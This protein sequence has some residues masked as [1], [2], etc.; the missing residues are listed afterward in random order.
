MSFW[1]DLIVHM[2]LHGV[3]VFLLLVPNECKLYDKYSFMGGTMCKIYQPS[4]PSNPIKL[5]SVHS[6]HVLYGF[7]RWPGC[8]EYETWRKGSELDLCLQPRMILACHCSLFKDAMCYKESFSCRCFRHV[9]KGFTGTPSSKE[10]VDIA[11][12]DQRG[13]EPWSCPL[14]SC[15]M[16]HV[17]HE[18]SKFL[19]NTSAIDCWYLVCLGLDL[20][21]SFFRLDG[22]LTPFGL[23]RS[24]ASLLIS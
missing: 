11:A 13:L 20:A 9:S 2:V 5:T 21:F 8:H 6:R 10:L 7:Q 3:T 4:Q 24:W 15:R 19:R 23:L 12:S 22:D 1:L 18:L 16:K 17:I 14:V